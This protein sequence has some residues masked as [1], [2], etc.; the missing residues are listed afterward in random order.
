[1]ADSAD[2]IAGVVDELDELTPAHSNGRK[3]HSL[4]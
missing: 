1:M 3:F 2:R 4:I